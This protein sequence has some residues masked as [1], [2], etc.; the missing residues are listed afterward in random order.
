MP[1]YVVRLSVHL[2]VCNVQVCDHIGWNTSKI[3]SWLAEGLRDELPEDG[4]PFISK[5]TFLT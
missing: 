2:S 4:G 5:I 3:I 1:Q